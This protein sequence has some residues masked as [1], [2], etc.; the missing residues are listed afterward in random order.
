M[1]IPRYFY[2][3]SP[4]GE[5]LPFKI[6]SYYATV[7]SIHALLAESDLLMWWQSNTTIISIHALLAESDYTLH[8]WALV[9]SIFLSTLSLRRATEYYTLSICQK[10]ISI[11]ALLAESDQ[12]ISYLM[13]IPVISIHALLAESDVP[14]CAAIS[15]MSAFLSTLSLRRATICLTSCTPAHDVFLSTLSLR[16]ATVFA[17]RG[18]DSVQ[19]SIHALLAESDL[20]LTLKT[21]I[22]GLFLS[23]LSLRRATTYWS[24]SSCTGIHFYPRSPCGERRYSFA[25]C[26]CFWIFL[27]TLSLRRATCY[28]LAVLVAIIF[29]STLSL[30]RAT[31][32]RKSPRCPV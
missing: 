10:V 17:V 18:Q 21:S 29:L 13:W 32:R 24:V 16:R 2:P 3:R 25:A 28:G 6:G 8:A 22:T 20:G 5:R 26:S 7:I 14:Y 1:F 30:R 27:S 11:H 15:T 23:T 31:P 19:I 9:M 4:C 12:Y